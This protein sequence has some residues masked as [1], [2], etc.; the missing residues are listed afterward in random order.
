MRFR[1]SVKFTELLEE[2]KIRETYLMVVNGVP[3]IRLITICRFIQLDY[4][5]VVK[6]RNFDYQTTI[7]DQFILHSR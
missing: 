3:A 2:S 5:P 1:R 4:I 7:R 6:V